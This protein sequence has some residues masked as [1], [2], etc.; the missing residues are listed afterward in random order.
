[1]GIIN[2]A[3]GNV[4]LGNVGPILSRKNTRYGWNGYPICGRKTPSGDVPCGIPAANLRYLNLSQLG[5]A[6]DSAITAFLRSILVIIGMGSKKQ[7]RWVYAPWVVA[8]MT[9][10]HIIR[11]R[12]IVQFITKPMRKHLLAFNEELTIPLWHSGASPQP[13]L[14]GRIDFLPKSGSGWATFS[15]VL[16]SNNKASGRTFYVTFSLAGHGDDVCELAA[17]A[18]AKMSGFFTWGIL[19]GHHDLL[20]CGVMPR[21]C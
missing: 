9:Y 8:M 6:A 21:D 14:A 3:I 15:D 4:H 20:G 2:G 17:A 1:M 10:Q 13:T 11:D 5:I 19:G 18:F 16:M 12:S 7:M